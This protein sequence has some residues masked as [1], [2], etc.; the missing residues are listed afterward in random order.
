MPAHPVP[1]DAEARSNAT[2]EAL[3]WALARPGLIRDLP[4]PGQEQIVEALI[5]RESAVHCVDPA[6]ASAVARTGAASVG[7]EAAGHVFA[8]V[9]DTAA[10]LRSLRCGSDLYPDEGATLVAA[11]N[12]GGGAAVRL[13]GPGIDGSVALTIGG[14]PDGFWQIRAEVMRY[15]MGFEVFL[16]DGARVLGLPRSTRVEVL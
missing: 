13:T 3:M 11:A 16:I 10:I 9:L 1:S 2:F 15:P 5:D 12:L 6:L 7:P 4:C 8:G 14:L